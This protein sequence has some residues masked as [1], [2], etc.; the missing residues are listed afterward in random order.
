LKNK[1][2]L[3]NPNGLLSFYLACIDEKDARAPVSSDASPAKRVAAE[4]EE[5][6]SGQNK[7][8]SEDWFLLRERNAL[9]RGGEGGI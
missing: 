8:Q 1:E 6:W 4:K 9:R 7:N 5:P 3:S 2:K